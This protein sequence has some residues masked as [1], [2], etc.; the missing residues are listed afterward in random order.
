[1]ENNLCINCKN[2]IAIWKDKN[3]QD[4]LCEDC[5]EIYFD[6]YMEEQEKLLYYEWFEE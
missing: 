3:T 5:K 6:N 1:M 4:I 2:K